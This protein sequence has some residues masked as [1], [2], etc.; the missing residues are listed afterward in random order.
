MALGYLLY[1]N[2]HGRYTVYFGSNGQVAQIVRTL[3]GCTFRSFYQEVS[4]SGRTVSIKAAR[5]KSFHCKRLRSFPLIFDLV[6]VLEKEMRR[7]LKSPAMSFRVKSRLIFHNLA[8]YFHSQTYWLSSDAVT[9]IKTQYQ[10][11]PSRKGSD[12]IIL[13]FLVLMK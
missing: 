2:K 8:R 10:Q 3:R 6:L 7:F 1:G 11:C 12:G 5:R 13:F 4:S 9:K